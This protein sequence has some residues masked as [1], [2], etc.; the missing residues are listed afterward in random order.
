MKEPLGVWLNGERVFLTD[1]YESPGR[2][3]HRVDVTLKEGQNTVLVKFSHAKEPG[4][5]S[6]YLRVG[7]A[8]GF[9]FS[10]DLEFGKP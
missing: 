8:W 7:D 5:L 2:D 4:Q 6:L 3:G 1:A 10:A 9:P